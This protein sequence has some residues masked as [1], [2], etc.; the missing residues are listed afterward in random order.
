MRSLTT[1]A[2]ESEERGCIVEVDMEQ[3]DYV[4]ATLDLVRTVRASH[5]NVY[6]VV[7]AYLHDN[8][9]GGWMWLHTSM[10]D[11]APGHRVG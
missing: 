6:G 8:L 5:L 7:Q 3:I 4:D 11:G 2:G 1:I 10:L 9:I